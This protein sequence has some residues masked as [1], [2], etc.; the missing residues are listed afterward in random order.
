[1]IPLPLTLTLTLTLP[2][3]PPSPLPLTR[4]DVVINERDIL[5]TQLIRRND[6]L[7]LLAEKLKVQSQT[8]STGEIEYRER[9]EDVR[10]LF[11]PYP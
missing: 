2:L 11:S 10:V 1:M 7:A 5:G 9:L 4:Y 8:I 3:P 6:E